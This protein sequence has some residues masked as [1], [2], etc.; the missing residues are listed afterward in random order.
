MSQSKA[1]LIGRKRNLKT[2]SLRFLSENASNVFRPHSRV[3]EKFEN[4]TIS[5]RLVF[6]FKF[7]EI[8]PVLTALYVGIFN[9]SF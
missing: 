3:P 6:G 7:N 8:L 1:P 5:G 4:P 9:F 2:A